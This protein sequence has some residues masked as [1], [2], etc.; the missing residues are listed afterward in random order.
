[1]RPRLIW[2]AV[3]GALLALAASAATLAFANVNVARADAPT[4]F[5]SATPPS[6]ELAA[7]FVPKRPVP[8][9][10][11][12]MPAPQTITIESATP[13]DDVPYNASTRYRPRYAGRRSGRPVYAAPAQ[14]HAGFFDPEGKGDNAFVLGIRGGPLVDPHIQ[15][16]GGVDWHHK[17]EKSRTVSGDPYSQGGTTIFPER[18][19]SSA[20]S[21]LLPI[22]LFIQ[23]SGDDSAPVVPYGG[24]SGGYHVLFLTADDYT[25]GERF[26]ATFG[27]FMWEGWA[28][29]ALPLS[30]QSRLFGEV[31]V[32]QGDAERDVQDLFGFEYRERVSLDGVGARFGLSW[33]F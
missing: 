9:G 29:A 16:G 19:L 7:G 21:D 24:L 3:L 10:R 22:Y 26:D 17:S 11:E 15:F 27:G 6:G 31:F 12:D 20:S 18:V 4:G 32:H 1:M 2:R 14:V 23:V 25:T 5:E 33:G 8:H 30:G 28:G 13:H